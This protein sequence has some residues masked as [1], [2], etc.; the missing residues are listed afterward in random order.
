MTA[1]LLDVIETKDVLGEGP[2]WNPRDQRLWWT[3][4][5]SRRLRRLDPA[6]RQVE[7][8]DTPERVG[9]IA[10]IE[11][12]SDRM[13]VA[14]ETGIALFDPTGGAVEW[15]HRS[16][17]LG[18]GRRYNDG[19]TDR[20]G[21]FWVG[22]MVEDPAK[23][24]ASTAHLWR[25]DGAGP[26][27]ACAEGIGISNS[28]ALSPDGRTLYFADTP[29][30]RIEAFDLD[31]DT[32]V[33]S[34][35]R[36]FAQVERGSPDGSGMDSE[37]CL[38]NA[39]WGGGAVV[40]HAPDGREI[41]VIETAA[42]QPTCVAFGGPDQRWMFVTS[43]SDGLTPEQSRAESAAGDVFIFELDTPGLAEPAFRLGGPRSGSG[44]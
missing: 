25:L 7:T 8:I 32:G 18:S 43:A 29:T 44:N 16:E 19:R 40:R 33:L 3:D 26:A 17:T 2:V 11:E 41:A 21:R 37:G 13:L 27:V 35:R 31:V 24:G 14:F 20:Q 9:A 12:R 30:R 42:S 36:V 15:L 4:I 34:G 38:W 5:Q 22:T 28:L 39:R 6:T 23:V 1:R 10:F